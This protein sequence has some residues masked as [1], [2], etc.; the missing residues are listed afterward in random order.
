MFIII[1]MYFQCIYKGSQ[2]EFVISIRWLI[3]F[4][5]ELASEMK[6]R[7]LA[8]DVIGDNVEAERAVVTRRRGRGD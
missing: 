5:I 7:S 4:Q 1:I 8:R 6:H 2:Q 3:K